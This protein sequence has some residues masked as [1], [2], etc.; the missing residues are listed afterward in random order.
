M[1]I[2]Q[3]I[4]GDFID[5]ASQAPVTA[6]GYI[7]AAVSQIDGR[8]GQ[9]YAKQH[10]ELIAAYMQTV[11]L[12]LG[13]ALIAGAIEELAAATERQATVLKYLG[14]GDAA[15]T[16]GAI[17]FLATRLSESIEGAAHIVAE[18]VLGDR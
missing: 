14:T 8:F 3:R 16:M 9:G 6:P 10:P 5:L 18:T 15:S 1:T 2:V 12:D 4:E 11:T 7:D 13:T 17:E